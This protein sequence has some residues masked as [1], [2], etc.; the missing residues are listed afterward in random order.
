MGVTGKGA[1][2]A[3]SGEAPSCQVKEP[4]LKISLPGGLSR[5]YSGK[6][7]GSL[8]GSPLRIGACE[9][10]CLCKSTLGLAPHH[11]ENQPGGVEGACANREAFKVL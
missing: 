10:G 4:E 5:S 7:V 8:R 11:A 2:R 6:Q 3:D 9:S 1:S